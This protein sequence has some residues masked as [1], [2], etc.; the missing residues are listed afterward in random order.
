M[1]SH[2][3]FHINIARSSVVIKCLSDCV[4]SCN[5]GC[6]IHP[7]SEVEIVCKRTRE[8]KAWVRSGH[9]SHDVSRRKLIA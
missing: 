2:F 6:D 3:F 4:I 8:E 9:Y 5:G 7:E 1:N